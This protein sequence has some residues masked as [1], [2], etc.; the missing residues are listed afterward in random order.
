MC[1]AVERG[2]E[3][4]HAGVSDI[5]F[6][7]MDLAR[8]RAEL[9]TSQLARAADAERAALALRA[10]AERAA[11]ESEQLREEQKHV[12]GQLSAELELARVET[13]RACAEAERARLALTRG[14]G[15]ADAA[16]TALEEELRIREARIEAKGLA[17]QS[18]LKQLQDSCLS[19]LEAMRREHEAV[20]AEM[21]DSEARRDAA[22]AAAAERAQQSLADV[23]AHAHARADAL[24]RELI[25]VRS[26]REAEMEAREARAKTSLFAS[27]ADAERAREATSQLRAAHA[28][29]EALRLSKHALDARLEAVGTV[30][31]QLA[32]EMASGLRRLRADVGR[33]RDAANTDAAA[34]AAALARLGPSGGPAASQGPSLAELRAKLRSD[35]LAHGMTE[36]HVDFFLSSSS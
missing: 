4:L 32:A 35:M 11:A 27:S 1:T 7:Q 28:E 16:D 12:L 23:C 24:Q 17:H 20:L 6:L 30:A 15:A 5:A 13:T 31:H 33:Q 3:M 14:A 18:Q 34:L 10:A 21:R 2:R 25:A 22:Q 29:A 8:T 26:A 9:E 19:R 36:R